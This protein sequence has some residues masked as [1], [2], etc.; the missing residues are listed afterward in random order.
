MS[1]G[2]ENLWEPERKKV[3]RDNAFKFETSAYDWQETL[4][5]LGLRLKTPIRSEVLGRM[6]PIGGAADAR[7]EDL[8]DAREELHDA[9]D[10]KEFWK[11][12]L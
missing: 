7:E 12:G 5:A 8:R 4:C 11:T 9:I 6:F 1:T 3:K 10:E 2:P